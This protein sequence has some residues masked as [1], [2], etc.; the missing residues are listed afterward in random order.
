M[1]MSVSEPDEVAEMKSIVEYADSLEAATAKAVAATKNAAAAK[2]VEMEAEMAH[3]KTQAP[4]FEAQDEAR[5][6]W[7][8]VD[9]IRAKISEGGAT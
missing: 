3:R 8:T 6:A 1:S 9:A 2:A 4:L 7:A 5:S